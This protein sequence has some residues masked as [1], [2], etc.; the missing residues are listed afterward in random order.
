MSSRITTIALDDHTH[1][2]KQRMGGNF[3]KFVRECLL[4]Y[5]AIV[6]DV[7]CPVERIEGQLYGKL[8]TPSSGR[9]CLKHWP[10]GRPQMA[11]WKI[12]KDMV[13][14]ERKPEQSL[15]TWPFLSDYESPQAWILKRSKLT[16]PPVFSIEDID[17]KG[18]A[19][20]EKSKKRSSLIGRMLNLLQK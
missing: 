12:Y 18:N 4:R 5:D 19:K 17:V 10:H 11:D 9:V 6:Y 7:E 20:P 15:R 13:I 3:S 14:M 8:C 1:A 16:N 2:I